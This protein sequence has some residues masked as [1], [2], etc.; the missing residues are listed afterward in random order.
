MRRFLLL[1]A[2][3]FYIGGGGER[4]CVPVFSQDRG[5]IR[6]VSVQS[7]TIK[8]STGFFARELGN[9]SLGDEVI[10]IGENGKWSRIRF[11]NLT[12]WVTS[13][14]LSARRIVASGTNASATELALAGKGFSPEMEVEYRKT[15]LDYSVVDFMEKI[16]IPREELLGFIT[17]GRLARGEN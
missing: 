9:L 10:L 5:I 4:A 15:G 17:E 13:T 2:V 7:T 11:G 3:V 6:F 12:G 14:S 1:F 16:T 8:E